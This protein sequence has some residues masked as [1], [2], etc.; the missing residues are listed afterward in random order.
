ML[1]VKRIDM[2]LD[3]K[4]NSKFNGEIKS[5]KLPYV[6]ICSNKKSISASAFQLNINFVLSY[7]YKYTYLCN[8]QEPNIISCF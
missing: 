4:N 3:F 6:I 7:M 8:L 1:T 5:D 2:I